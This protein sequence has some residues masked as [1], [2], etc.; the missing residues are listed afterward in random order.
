MDIDTYIKYRVFRKKNSN[1]IHCLDCA[2]NG[3]GNVDSRLSFIGMIFRNHL[4]DTRSKLNRSKLDASGSLRFPHTK[5]HISNFENAVVFS[6]FEDMYATISE[7]QS[8]FETYKS[9]IP[10]MVY[11]KI[12]YYASLTYAEICRWEKLYAHHHPRD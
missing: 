10:F 12:T 2:F 1:I 5:E 8:I 6:F 9:D 3:S 4:V 11:V 7:L